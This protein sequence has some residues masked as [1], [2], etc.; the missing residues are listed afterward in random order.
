[1]FNGGAVNKMFNWIFGCSAAGR[2]DHA[3]GEI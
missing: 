3:V 2:P 1:V